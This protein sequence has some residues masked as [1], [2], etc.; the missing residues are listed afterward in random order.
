MSATYQTDVLVIGSGGAGC[1]AALE[2]FRAGADVIIVAKGAFGKSGTTA[3]RV[4]DTAGYNFA[5]GIVDPND[6]PEIHYQDIIKAGLGMTYE[7]LAK[8]LSEEA[9][10][11]GPYLEGL[12]VEF[13]KDPSTG[14]YIEVRGCFSTK[15]RMHVLKDHGEPIIKALEKE[16]NGHPIKIHE[17]TMI[18]KLLVSNGTC[19]GAVG[20]DKEGEPVVFQAKTVIIA[21]GGAG[22]LFKYTLTPPDITGDGYALGLSAGADLVNMEYMQVVVGTVNPTKNQLNA[23]LWCARPKLLNGSEEE[24][25]G[26]YLPEG[27]TEDMVMEA[28][29]THFPFSTRDNSRFIE[30]AIQ[31]EILEGRGTAQSGVY[32]DL[33]G[34]NDEVVNTLPDDSPLPKVWPIV[35]EFMAQRGFK[36]ETEPIQ[37]GCFAHAIN[38]GLKID[39]WGRTTISGLYAAGEVAGGPH[40]ADRLGG[41]MLLTCQVYGARAGKDAALKADRS[42]YNQIPEEQVKIEIARLLKM[43]GGEGMQKTDELK[44]R[45]QDAMWKG[46]LVVRSEES[47]N[48]TLDELKSL[49]EEINNSSIASKDAVKATLEL[50]NLIDIGEVITR[51][52]LFRRETRGSHYREDYPEIDPK[53]ET[54][55]LVRKNSETGLVIIKENQS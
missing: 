40:G 9:M 22:Q 26:N 19:F 37:V 29:S 36:I 13:Q 43:S 34:I 5:D 7:E 30:I 3:F 55:L 14:R 50:E 47:L 15:P 11:T 41:N 2:A 21:A 17:H 27:M 48:K 25:L 53:W 44:A 10:E 51:V 52:A 38:G 16:I 28:K 24:F 35:K 49:R 54:K 31:K 33:T 18:T 46:V 32:V 23:F 1:R 20:L 4:A 6:S 8:I 42:S 45:L 39:E 12:G